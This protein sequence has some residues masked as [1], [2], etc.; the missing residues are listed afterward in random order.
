MVPE[1]ERETDPHVD[2]VDEL[3]QGGQDLDPFMPRHGWTWMMD[4]GSSNS[5]ACRV[6][7]NMTFSAVAAG[8]SP[9]ILGNSSPENWRNTTGASVADTLSC[10]AFHL[11]TPFSLLQIGNIQPN[12]RHPAF[13][14]PVAFQNSRLSPVFRAFYL[15]F[16]FA[17]F[18]FLVY[19]LYTLFSCAQVP[20][21]RDSQQ[22]Q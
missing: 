11:L 6:E 12:N 18:L 8:K 21:C 15:C 13:I 16:F 9:P 10:G 3:P 20:P 2:D 7:L 1:E 22:P 5:G 17:F 4:L 19:T 14:A